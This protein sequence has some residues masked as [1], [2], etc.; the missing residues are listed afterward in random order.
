MLFNRL[1]PKKKGKRVFAPVMLSRLQRLGINKSHPEDLTPEEVSQFV[2]LDIDP[3]TITWQRVMDTNDR[4]LRKIEVGKNPTEVGHE[5]MTGFDIAVASE[6]MAVLA[7]SAD[8][9]DMRQR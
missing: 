4:F 2:R 6:V 5:R 1:C 7:L 9:K 8:L 3:S